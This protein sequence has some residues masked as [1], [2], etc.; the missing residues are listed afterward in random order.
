[1]LSLQNKNCSGD[2]KE[3]TKVSRA[4]KAE[5]H[6][7]WQFIGLWWQHLVKV[8]HGIKLVS[9]VSAH[10]FFFLSQPR[11]LRLPVR[12]LRALLQLWSQK[13][14]ASMREVNQQTIAGTLSWYK[15]LLLRGFNRIR[16]KQNLHMRRRKVCQDS[17]SRRTDRKLY[18]Q[19]TRWN[20]G[21]RVKVYHG[22]T[23]FNT[24][25]I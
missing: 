7:Q 15:I 24:S 20:L 3:F 16:V 22:I 11:Q 14:M 5:S 19:T 4:G 18:T 10:V 21:Q 25:S 8:Y 12:L 13:S 1:M 23:T 6:L 9:A 17:W 2:R